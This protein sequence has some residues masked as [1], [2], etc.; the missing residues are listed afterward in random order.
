MREKIINPE[1]NRFRL[2]TGT[3]PDKETAEI[4]AEELKIR[5]GWIVYIIPEQ[6]EKDW[7]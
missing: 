4:M 1:N 2:I 7:Q 3:F 6:S 5:Y